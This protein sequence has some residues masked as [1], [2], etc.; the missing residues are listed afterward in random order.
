MAHLSQDEALCD[1][2]EKGHDVHNRTASNEF[3]ESEDDVLPE[4]RRIAK[5]VN[6]G[7]MYGA[8]PFR[9]SQELDIT[10]SDAGKIIESYFEQFS[11]IRRYINSILEKARKDRFVETILGRRRPVW[12]LDSEN[13]LRRKA[14]ERMTIYMPIQGS[15]A[16]MI[17]LAMITIQERLRLNKMRSKMILQ[18][19]DELLFEFHAEE[20]KELIPMVIDSMEKAMPLSVPVIVDY[21]IGDNWYEAH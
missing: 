8:G 10:R 18:I 4:M 3:G 11:G 1:A 21:G 12:D 17:K 16:E 7:I 5:G 2:F 15:A 6:F 9:M 19:H 20:E 14:A 13:G